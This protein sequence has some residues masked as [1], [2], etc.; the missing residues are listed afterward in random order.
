MEEDLSDYN[1]DTVVKIEPGDFEESEGDS[2]Q[3]LDG[4]DFLPAGWC[5]KT[6]HGATGDHCKVMTAD[7]L[8][9][10]SKVK[11]LSYMID[12]QFSEEDLSKMRASL[13][14][15]GWAESNLLPPQWRYRKCKAER[16]EY[17][18]ISP[19][20][21]IF[22]SRRSLIDFFR[23]SEEFDDEDVQNALVFIEEIKAV[24]VNNLQDW[25]RSGNT[26]R[27]RELRAVPSVSLLLLNISTSP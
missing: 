19:S 15:D 5:Y 14:Y 8:V 9:F 21:E 24:W 2:K 4:S 11:A 17:N 6:V 16:N 7:G 20:G 22:T 13:L 26:R 10:T 1:D 27:H 12:N 18:F 3:W 25:Y 23:S